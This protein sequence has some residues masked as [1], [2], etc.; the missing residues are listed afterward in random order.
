M[1]ASGEICLSPMTMRRMP[2]W[3]QSLGQTQGQTEQGTSTDDDLSPIQISDS[4]QHLMVTD[5][6]SVVTSPPGQVLGGSPPAA[7]AEITYA[8]FISFETARGFG[9]YTNDQYLP[10]DPTGTQSV[11]TNYQT[12]I[13]AVDGYDN[14]V[15][16]GLFEGSTGKYLGDGGVSGQS[17]M[18]FM[19][20]NGYCCRK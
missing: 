8:N 3:A 2:V 1:M 19:T 13:V 4:A 14:I 15:D 18:D 12:I 6:G 17:L 10:P 16:S 9:L 20:T 7:P 11:G 5:D